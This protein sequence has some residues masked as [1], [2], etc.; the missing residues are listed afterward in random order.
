MSG[1]LMEF[2]KKFINFHLIF[3]KLISKCTCMTNILVASK[4]KEEQ[5]KPEVM[6]SS[7][8]IKLRLRLRLRV[9]L[10]LGLR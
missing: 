5:A 4:N 1:P 6:P 2:A 10:R 9:R 3:E 8:L 7:S